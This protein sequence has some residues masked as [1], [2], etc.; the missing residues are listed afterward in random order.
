[1]N[2]THAPLTTN[3]G[4][5]TDGKAARAEPE[6]ARTGVGIAAKL[7]TMV[8]IPLTALVVLLGFEV[9]NR[10]SRERDLQSIV[11]STVVLTKSEHLVTELQLEL[12][13]AALL[14]SSDGPDAREALLSQWIET[15]A[16]LADFSSALGE[17]DNK[18]EAELFAQP[19]S[20]LFENL[21]RLADMRERIV[22]LD[23]VWADSLHFY[24]DLVED[25]GEGLADGLWPLVRLDPQ[26]AGIYTGFL[27]ITAALEAASLERA[28]V[29]KVLT[30]RSIDANEL[31]VLGGLVGRQEASLQAFDDH[32]PPE[33]RAEYE[34]RLNATKT[35]SAATILA[36]FSAGE[37]SLEPAMWFWVSSRRIS[38]LHNIQHNL[39]E[40][41]ADASNAAAD[42][43]RTAVW[44]FSALGLLV[45]A[46]SFYAA[47]R[48]GRRLSR[49]T[50]NL[51]RVARA[52]QRGDFSQRADIDVHD[53][54]GTLADAFNQMTDDLTTL[55]QKLETKVEK[56][57]TELAA[58]EAQ[59]RAMLEAI[60]DLIVRVSSEG[61][62]LEFIHGGTAAIFPLFEDLHSN[63]LEEFLPRHLA[64]QFVSASHQAHRSGEVQ[65]LEYQVSSAGDT[66][67]KEARIVAIPGSDE[68]LLVIRDITEAKA[69]ERHLEDLIRSKDDFVASISHELR[70]PLTAVLGFAELLQASPED[71]SADERKEMMQSITEEA[72]DISNIVEDLLVSARTKIGKLHVTQVTVDLREQLTQVLNAWRAAA[73]EHVEVAD[74]SVDT[75]GDPQRVRQIIRNLL[76]N[77]ARYGG[78]H[79]RA[80]VF[81]R[82]STA[83]VEVCD[84]GQGVPVE[85]R[86]S[87]F[88][89]YNQAQAGRH[90]TGSIGLGLTI[91]RSLARL[92]GG[93]LTYRYENETSIFELTLPI[94]NRA[95]SSNRPLN[96]VRA[97]AS[98]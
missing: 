86:E 4:A 21:E 61:A 53:E 92:M 70:T 78:D 57:T 87:I 13:R 23:A 48:I 51:A 40:D 68:T 65:R 46:T 30:D 90:Q 82:N 95:D 24:A 31:I 5:D 14:S 15:D 19:F 76:T 63:N 83:V 18:Y 72:T 26:V 35:V 36:R 58:N 74:G 43:S 32:T 7:V 33:L 17:F 11:A 27:D 64:E 47:N 81:S 45:L 97:E 71:F 67:E 39:L 55:N 37:F 75:L 41:L 29:S 62:Y 79:V 28:I 16:A 52:I 12:G 98:T 2:R 42:R 84:N 88:D 1:M 85:D 25:M 94:A 77:A 10:I 60:P 34:S 73:A 59:N 20:D 6:P 96:L 56:R 8:A 66:Q 22:D 69:A 49:R 54:L 9:A 80:R 89:P 3:T 91:S 50:I 44:Q 93:D 38:A